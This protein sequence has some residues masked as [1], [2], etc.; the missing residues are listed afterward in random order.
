MRNLC[1]TLAGSVM[2]RGASWAEPR[3]LGC[4]GDTAASESLARR[5]AGLT[6][7]SAFAILEEA[8]LAA[9]RLVERDG[10]AIACLAE[11]LRLAGDRLEGAALQLALAAALEGETWRAAEPDDEDEEQAAA[12]PTLEEILEG[13]A[14]ALPRFSR[15]PWR[16]WEAA[17]RKLPRFATF[18]DL[19]LALG[20]RNTWRG[21]FDLARALVHERIAS[22][23]AIRIAAGR[24]RHE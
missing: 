21:A 10:G 9:E 19:Q 6:A 8:D 1:M 12:S 18:A 3:E 13:P 20:T 2:A 15:R 7:R 22:M 16:Q 14:P 23:A 5:L 24:V 4:A 11:S 17:S